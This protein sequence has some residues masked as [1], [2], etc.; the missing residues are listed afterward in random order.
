[1]SIQSSHSSMLNITNK[2]SQ[3]DSS[4]NLHKHSNRTHIKEKRKSLPVMS[5]SSLHQSKSSSIH[6]QLQNKIK[7]HSL[8]T[9]RIQTQNKSTKSQ[10]TSSNTSK[11]CLFK[12]NTCKI[13]D[14]R[15]SLP[16]ISSTSSSLQPTSMYKQLQNKTKRHSLAT[17]E[18]IQTLNKSKTQSQKTNST[19]PKQCLFIFDIISKLNSIEIKVFLF[20]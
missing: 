14:K 13:L 11:Q 7:R 20:K 19:T 15:K 10:K 16:V 5:A 4:V 6:M 1:M 8:A 2:S 18:R 3:N 17:E 9:E 12:S